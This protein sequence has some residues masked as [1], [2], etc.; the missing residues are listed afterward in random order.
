MAKLNKDA[1]RKYEDFLYQLIDEGILSKED[2]CDALTRYL[3]DDEIKGFIESEY[4]DLLDEA[5]GQSFK[6]LVDYLSDNENIEIKEINEDGEYIIYC[7]NDGE[8]NPDAIVGMY[9]DDTIYAGLK[10]DPD[11]TYTDYDTVEEF[12]DDLE[13]NF[14]EVEED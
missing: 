1:S 3:S 4:G 2:I 10:D 5:E 14:Q 11:D 6:E 12:I 7:I 9:S 13:E 8:Q